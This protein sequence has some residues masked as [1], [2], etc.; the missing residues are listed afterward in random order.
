M[1]IEEELDLTK[2]RDESVLV[3]QIRSYISEKIK[4]EIRGDLK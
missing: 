1:K 2:L 3:N 4:K